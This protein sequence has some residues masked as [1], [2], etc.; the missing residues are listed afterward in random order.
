MLDF[1]SWLVFGSEFDKWTQE[2]NAWIALSMNMLLF[3]ILGDVEREN[4]PQEFNKQIL[5]K[6]G[7]QL[8]YHIKPAP[9]LGSGILTYSNVFQLKNHTIGKVAWSSPF[10]RIF[11]QPTD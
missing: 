4:N 8:S 7:R 5:Q 6:E 11:A 3:S 9:Q 2:L 1:E 10:T